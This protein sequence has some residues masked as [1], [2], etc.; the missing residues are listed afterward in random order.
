MREIL[1]HGKR[2][3]NGEWVEGFYGLK[4]EKT[5]CIMTNTLP[6]GLWQ[7]CYS[8][9]HPVSP[10]TVGQYTGMTDKNGKRIFEG[11][12]IKNTIGQVGYIA[13]LQ[14]EAGWVIVWETYDSRMGHRARGCGYDSDR[15]IE[16]IGN[17]HDN[18]ELIK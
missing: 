16:V 2:I 10:G 15:T 14:Q 9:D 11:D 4:G 7:E 5:H 3:D 17:I 1:F 6:S 12:I 8:T 13:F 18:P